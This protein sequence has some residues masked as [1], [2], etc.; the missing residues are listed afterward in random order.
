M[1]RMLIV[2]DEK[3][4]LNSLY[5]YFRDLDDLE[6]DIYKANSAEEALE[7]LNRAKMDG[8]LSDICMPG[9]SGLE[10][11]SQI[12]DRWPRCRVVF[13]TGHDSFEYVYTAS[14]YD[15]VNYLLKSEGYEVLEKTLRKV[16][17]ELEQ[18]FIEKKLL[19]ELEQQIENTKSILQKDYFIGLLSGEYDI[20]PMPN[21]LDGMLAALPVL[22]LICRMDNIPKGVTLGEKMKIAHTVHT[23]LAHYVSNQG[24]QMQ[25]CMYQQNIIW[26][27]QQAQ[28]VDAAEEGRV[29]RHVLYIHENLD[30]VQRVCKESLNLSLS[31]ILANY[32]VQWNEVKGKYDLLQ[33]ILEYTDGTET[34]IIL[35]EENIEAF[36]NQEN[37]SNHTMLE[38]RRYVEE[39]LNDDLS[40]IKL[41]DFVHFNPS[42]LSRIF[43][44]ETGFN[45]FEY[46]RNLRIKRAKELLKKTRM[47]IGE[48]AA[49]V[50]FSS[51]KYFA[52]AFKKVTNM[53]PQEWV[54]KNR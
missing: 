46:V 16:V 15:G 12:K 38:I 3:I 11:L 44:K 27:F 31:F 49:C 23:V 19:D 17:S 18:H 43:K 28:E 30:A 21:Q 20:A 32:F 50:G 35:S 54:E 36:C 52:S 37:S 14:K 5:N 29:M 8:V 42:Y 13:L 10:L 7:W 9:M 45:L 33:R 1:Y 41:A 34:E 24:Y 2:D 26:F 25:M 40:L 4:I 22:L 51:P 47:K 39:H 53:T 48:V 6:L